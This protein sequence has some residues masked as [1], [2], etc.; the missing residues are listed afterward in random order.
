MPTLAPDTPPDRALRLIAAD[1]QADLG[2]YRAIVLASRR[3]VGIHQT[4]VALRRLRAA[5]TLFRGAVADNERRR[6]V[7]ALAAEAKWFAGECAPARDL[8]VFLTETLEEQAPPE[9]KRIAARLAKTHLERARTALAG[10]RFNAFDGLLTAFVEEAPPAVEG[11]LD[12][13]GRAVLERRHAKVEQRGRHLSRLD[14]KHLH[15]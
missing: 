8:H 3:S 11:R 12:E 7:R 15:K 1:C 4:R 9:V 14:R 5:L 13:F 10:A 6:R 2:K